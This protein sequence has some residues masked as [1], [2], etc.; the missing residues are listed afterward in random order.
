MMGLARALDVSQAELRH[1]QVSTENWRHHLASLEQQRF[2]ARW[3]EDEGRFA[4]D[5]QG[6][7]SDRAVAENL[8][9]QQLH[10]AVVQKRAGLAIVQNGW[11]TP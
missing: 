8:L 3:I 1:E 5:P 6:T 7:D 10:E 11:T 9:V 2:G 4:I